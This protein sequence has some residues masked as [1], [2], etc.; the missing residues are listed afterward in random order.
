MDNRKAHILL[1]NCENKDKCPIDG[2]FNFEN[3]VYQASII[4]KKHR[5]D[6]DI[7][8]GISTGNLKL[9]LYNRRHSFTNPLFRNQSAFSKYFWSL[10]ER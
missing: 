10:K 1:Y 9:R 3:V 4:P 6:V 5:N 8:T 2:R 7:S